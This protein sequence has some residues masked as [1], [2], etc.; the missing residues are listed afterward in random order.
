MNPLINTKLSWQLRVFISNLVLIFL[1]LLAS[2]QSF[3]YLDYSFNRLRPQLFCRLDMECS[4]IHHNLQEK[5][6]ITQFASWP[7]IS[8]LGHSH[9]YAHAPQSGCFSIRSIIER[10]TSHGSQEDPLILIFGVRCTEELLAAL[11]RL[12]SLSNAYHNSFVS[13]S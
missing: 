8:P 5:I 10:I 13:D 11:R 2:R 4:F 6:Y 7:D 3:Y 12:P 9:N 1:K